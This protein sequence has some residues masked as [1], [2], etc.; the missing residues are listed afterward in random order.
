M[1]FLSCVMDINGGTGARFMRPEFVGQEAEDD[2][3][4]SF[5]RLTV[6]GVSSEK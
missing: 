3:A 6:F 1:Q 4:R 2:G 5:H